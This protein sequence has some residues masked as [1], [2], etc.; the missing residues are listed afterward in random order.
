MSKRTMEEAN[1]EISEPENTI[2]DN[3]LTK[4]I[5]LQQEKTLLKTKETNEEIDIDEH[6]VYKF[7]LIFNTLIQ[8]SYSQESLEETDGFVTVHLTNT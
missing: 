5:K 1:N 4:K 8:T 6:R 3:Q 2:S 7:L